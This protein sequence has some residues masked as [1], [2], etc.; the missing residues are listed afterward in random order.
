MS[1]TQ[2]KKRKTFIFLPRLVRLLRRHVL[3]VAEEEESEKQN[4]RASIGEERPQTAHI[5]NDF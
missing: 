5:T 1:A 3:Q 4:K 2:K